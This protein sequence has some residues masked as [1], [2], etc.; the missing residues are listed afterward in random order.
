MFSHP[1]PNYEGHFQIQQ[2]IMKK[3]TSFIN[4]K[5]SRYLNYISIDKR[6]EEKKREKVETFPFPNRYGN[7][8]HLN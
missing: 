7:E 4:H 8:N 2:S 5:Q 3:I 6:K 1:R